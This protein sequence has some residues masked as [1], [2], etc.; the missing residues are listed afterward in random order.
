MQRIVAILLLGAALVA[1]ASPVPAKQ[2]QDFAKS[3]SNKGNAVGV[4]SWT[5]K[6]AGKEVKLAGLDAYVATPS[7][8]FKA[9][10]LMI[11][12][13][14][15]WRVDAARVWADNMAKQGFLVVVPDYFKGEPR[16]KTDSPDTFAAWRAKFPRKTV[17][18]QSTDMIAAIKAAY[19]SVKKVG[20][21]G[22]CW[23]GLYSVL[24]AGGKAPAV[25]AAVVYH[26]SLL[27]RADIEAIAA[28]INFQQADP[29]LDNQIKTDFYK[30]IKAILDDKAKKGLDA[31]I[32]YYPN[33]PH[34]Y[35]LRGA[36]ATV[37]ASATT[38][39]SSGAA[40]FKKHLN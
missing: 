40:F 36:N 10:V 11:S 5:G 18:K 15:G 29:A 28:P 4:V 13:V 35:S 25:N 21:A 9:A 33:M 6:G 17:M 38:A 34:G 2:V 19:P 12:D 16:K 1:Q 3:H 7:G 32:T 24:L 31:S 14:F 37:S 30:E 26:G 8:P 39:F 22:F 23:G 20:V 27:T